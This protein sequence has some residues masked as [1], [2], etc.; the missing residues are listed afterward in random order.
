MGLARLVISM[1]RSHGFVYGIFS[2][3]AALAAGLLSGVL[4]TGARKGH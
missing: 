1:A 4:F 3:A 2:V